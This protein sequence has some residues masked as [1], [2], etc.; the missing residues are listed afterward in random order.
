M[1]GGG[2]DNF[3]VAAHIGLILHADI[4]DYSTFAKST[5]LGL[6]VV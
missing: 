6:K 5:Q 4:V 3:D 2:R 1:G